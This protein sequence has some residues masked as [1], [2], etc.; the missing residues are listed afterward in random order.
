MLVAV[1]NL[2]LERFQG[3][4]LWRGEEYGGDAI[5]LNLLSVTALL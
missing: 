3:T 1:I 4:G 5:D 2:L